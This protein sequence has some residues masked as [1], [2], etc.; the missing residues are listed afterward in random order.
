MKKKLEKKLEKKLICML[1]AL[2]LCL[3]AVCLAETEEPEPVLAFLLES[4]Q[5]GEVCPGVTLG[6]TYEAVVQAG[7][8]LAAEPETENDFAGKT[9]RTFKVE[10]ESGELTLNETALREVGFQFL[11]DALLNVS[12]YCL[13]D[14]LAQPFIEQLDGLFGEHTV[15]E[16]RS[17]LTWILQVD[18]QTIQ[19]SL[20]QITEGE[21]AYASSIQVTAQDLLPTKE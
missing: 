18:E 16:E 21:T 11:D 10:A 8:V 13:R 4:L 17:I 12:F 5:Q 20:V 6:T 7:V 3:P 2:L 15:M 1:L 9:S 19:L 14:A